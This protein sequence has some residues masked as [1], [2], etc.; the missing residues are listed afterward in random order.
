MNEI[1][2]G[3]QLSRGALRAIAVSHAAGQQQSQSASSASSA[4]AGNQDQSL[5]DTGGE[6][7]SS[8]TE[9]YSSI[10]PIA[11]LLPSHSPTATAFTHTT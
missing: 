4:A 8:W 9:P 5:Q 6:D 7:K 3:Q 2:R 10:N 11:G 1:I